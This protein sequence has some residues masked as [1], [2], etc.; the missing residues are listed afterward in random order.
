MMGRDLLAGAD[1]ERMRGMTCRSSRVS[2]SLSSCKSWVFAVSIPC[3]N[4]QFQCLGAWGGVIFPLVLQILRSRVHMYP[5]LQICQARHL[6]HAKLCQG[7][8]QGGEGVNSQTPWH[9]Y[10][11]YN[12]GI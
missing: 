5:A 10:E 1:P 4:A 9:R 6:H 7:G 8:N 2:S 12:L 3:R 11:T